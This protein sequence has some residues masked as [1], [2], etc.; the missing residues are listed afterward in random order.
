[1]LLLD[2]N[3]TCKVFIVEPI[4]SNGNVYTCYRDSIPIQNPR[5]FSPLPC[6]TFNLRHHYIIILAR[7][8]PYHSSNTCHWTGRE[9]KSSVPAD[10]S[11]P[12]RQRRPEGW[13]DALRSAEGPWNRRYVNEILY[14]LPIKS[15][16]KRLITFLL[17]YSPNRILKIINLFIYSFVLNWTTRAISNK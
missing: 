1:M 15:I 6:T 14:Y 12:G 3:Y 5:A 13:H 7:N 9:V 11:K 16:M 2:H 8:S 17:S 10:Y 4:F